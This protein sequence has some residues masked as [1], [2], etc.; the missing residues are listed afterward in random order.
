MADFTVDQI[1]EFIRLGISMPDGSYP[2]PDAQHLASA[3]HMVGLGKSPDKRIRLHIIKRAK[4]L[5]LLDKI[6]DN[7]SLDGTLKH[8]MELNHADSE[9]TLSTAVIVAVPSQ[10]DQI[11]LVGDEDKHAT[12]LY[13]GETKTLPAGAKEEILS[14]LKSAADMFSVFSSR[15]KDIQRLGPENPPA[16]VA[17]LSDDVLEKIRELLLINSKMS[18]YLKNANQFPEYNPHVT[19][20]YPD[21]FEEDQV[22]ELVKSLFKVKFDRLALWWNGEQIEFDLN[23][24]MAVEHAVESSATYMSDP[25][26]DF[27]AHHGVKGQKWGVRR[28]QP[29]GGSSSGTSSAGSRL[30]NRI[31]GKDSAG[32]KVT[33]EHSKTVGGQQV[34]AETA[35]KMAK[36]KQ[37][38]VITLQGDK[39]SAKTMIKKKDGSWEETHLSSDAEAFV[40]ARQKPGSE[41]SNKELKDTLNR[42]RMIKEYNDMF[43]PQPNSALKQKVDAMNLQK[44]YN[45]LYRDMHPTKT[46]KVATF[47]AGATAAYAAYNKLNKE[48]GGALGKT[49]SGALGTSSGGKHRK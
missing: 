26:K 1:K 10:L 33:T 2:I 7:W 21:Y 45:T 27:L 18:E 31:K 36:M 48:T 23:D 12:I 41:M 29:S 22:R 32:T 42:A 40:K 14:I 11:R 25:V 6:P 28:E 19:L 38:T 37:G 47:V 20:G 49:I 15:I 46:Q 30:L 3:I 44:Q 39:G 35:R 13:F 16:L 24:D 4:K 9:E 17:M 34:G 43:S 8:S 5:N